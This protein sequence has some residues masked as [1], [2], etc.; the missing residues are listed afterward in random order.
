M[1]TKQRIDRANEWYK[2][3]V[4]FPMTIEYC[5]KRE[6][7]HVSTIQRRRNCGVVDCSHN[8][9]YYAKRWTEEEDFEFEEC[10]DED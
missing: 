10:V 2:E 7:V 3:N 4:M 9:E 5:R 6:C 8:P 1:T